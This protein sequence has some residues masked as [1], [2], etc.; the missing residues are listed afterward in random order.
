MIA[1]GTAHNNGA[2]LASY[3]ITGKDSE[4]AELAELRGFA[5]DDIQEAF[6]SVHVMAE[7][8][9][10]EQ[11]FFHVQVRTPDDEHLTTEQWHRIADR[12]ET[13]LGLKDQP[14]AIAFHT[15]T[16][17]GHTHMHVA[18][19]RIDHETMTARPLP[20]FKLRLKEVSRELEIEMGLTRVT[21]QRHG[22][23]LAPNRA[24]FEQARRL[25]IDIHEVR[26]AIRECWDH[27][28]SGPSFVAALSEQNLVL[29][30]GD[31]RSFVVL[32]RAGGMH[33]LGK[34]L[35][36]HTVS[37]VRRRLGALDQLPTVG[38]AR[39]A[40][41]LQPRAPGLDELEQSLAIEERDAGALLESITRQRA[42]FNARDLEW[43]IARHVEDGAEIGR[44]SAEV[45]QHADLVALSGDDSTLRYTTRGVLASERRVLDD[46]AA[47]ARVKC[48]EVRPN[49][50]GWVLKQE[51]YQSIS[52]EQVR[53][54]RHATGAEGLVLINGQ[55]GTGKSYTMSAI[56]E[57]YE[58]SG[59]RVVGLAPTNVV[60]DDMRESGFGRARTLHSE[61]FAIENGRAQWDAQT[62]VIVDE[63][64]M[65]DTNNLGRLTAYAHSSGAKLVLIGDDR[66]LS[67]IERGGL[68]SVLKER[69]G[70]AELT[71]VRRQ[72]DVEDRHA[73]QTMAKGNFREALAM[74]Q[75]KGAIVWKDSQSDAADALIKQWA[76]DN[77]KDPSKS[78]FVFAYT[79]HDVDELN[80]A[81]RQLRLERGEVGLSISFE[82]KHGLAEFGTNDR[83]Q[84]TGTDKQRGI[85]NGQAGTVQAIDGSTI[86]VLLD[87]KKKRQVEFDVTAFRDFR[88]GYAGTIYKGQGRTLDQTY[89][90]H[91]E[92]WRA[93][94]SYVALTRHSHETKLF[95]AR[96][97]TA[98][99]RELASQMAR[100]DDRR[101]AHHFLH[102]KDHS[103][104]LDLNFG[105]E[106]LRPEVIDWSK[107]F[108][109]A[110]Y[111]HTVLQQTSP[112]GSEPSRNRMSRGR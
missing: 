87:G 48:H 58:A 41:G 86:T 85:Y 92:H 78:R 42:T 96:D 64:A 81:I 36:G 63:A 34:R 102:G 10:A 80:R 84:F 8:T 55:A 47:L 44:F 21:N 52:R 20:F 3:L 112:R 40:L 105:G 30:R 98:N 82:T 62:L 33:A 17:T 25:G 43:T 94:S 16:E 39:A 83:I 19:S 68:F 38:E 28:D 15:N 49:S 37:E 69:H 100:L 99:L 71:E 29:C 67:S 54:L 93:T 27:S 22:L 73:S 5:F 6:R 108:A 90:F 1:K 88:H 12:I 56:R 61:L 75:K 53:A 70:V 46:A 95:V 14:R 60:A 106:T 13:K 4:R 11:P 35:L 23:A 111:R 101:A 79:N 77:G 9:R 59:Y 24:E 18:W 109:D 103:E 45:L 2:K 57:V 110:Q 89:L 50:W 7:A 74:Y 26:A 66:Q 65:I 32:D 91:S 97:T 76:Q 72:Q 31:R 104:D 107:Y 51:K